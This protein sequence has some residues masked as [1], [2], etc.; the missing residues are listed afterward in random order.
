MWLSCADRVRRQPCGPAMPKAALARIAR[1]RGGLKVHPAATREA[2]RPTDGCRQ[3]HPHH[4]HPKEWRQALVSTGAIRLAVGQRR[5]VQHQKSPA[6][7]LAAQLAAGQGAKA[8]QMG[9]QPLRKHLP[10]H[11]QKERHPR[12]NRCLRFPPGRLPRRRAGWPRHPRPPD[13]GGCFHRIVGLNV[14]RRRRGVILGKV[15]VVKGL[16]RPRLRLPRWIWPLPHPTNPPFRQ[17]GVVS[18][19]FPRPLSLQR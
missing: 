2:G 7:H 8:F 12:P 15:C 14:F 16:A 17:H 19:R 6:D 5:W 4:P 3:Y 1:H 18:R 11:R 9:M 13:R 10:H